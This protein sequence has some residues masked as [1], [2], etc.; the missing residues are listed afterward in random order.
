MTSIKTEMIKVTLPDGT[1]KEV[2]IN[3][4]SLEIAQS[5]SEGLARI[6]GVDND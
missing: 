1:L 6:L 4:T 5:I 2:K 3:S